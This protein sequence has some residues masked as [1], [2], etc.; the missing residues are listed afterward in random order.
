MAM[1]KNCSDKALNYINLPE[2]FIAGLLMIINHFQIE[3]HL[4]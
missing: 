2:S 4:N 1:H 3:S